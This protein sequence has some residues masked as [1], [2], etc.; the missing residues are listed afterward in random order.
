MILVCRCLLSA[1]G[2]KKAWVGSSGSKP[3][4][5]NRSLEVEVRN[6]GLDVFRSIRV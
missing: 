6:T 5:L 1:G 2:W 4:M 3:Y